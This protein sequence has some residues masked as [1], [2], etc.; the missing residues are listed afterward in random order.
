MTEETRAVD[1]SVVIP[2]LNEEENLKELHPALLSALESL[3]RTFE[4]LYVDD[5][6]TDASVNI[7]RAFAE[8]DRRVRVLV[9]PRK[10]GQ[11]AALTAGIDHAAGE[12]IVTLDADLQNDP[13][14]ISILIEKIAE[15]YDLVCGW[16][17]ERQ[18]SWIRRL[19]SWGA[20]RL[21]RMVSGLRLHDVGCTLRACRA[22]LLKEVSLYGEMH[23]FIPVYG[24]LLGARICEIPVTHHPRRHGKAKYGLARTPKV[25]LDLLVLLLLGRFIT[26]PIHLFGAIGGLTIGAG[27]FCGFWVLR[28]IYLD[29]A[30]KAHKN[31]LL[32]LAVFLALLGAQ[33]LM[34]GLLAELLTRVYYES[35]GKRIYLIRERINF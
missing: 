27:I 1:I 22:D 4:V 7:L 35:R 12:I 33:M 13:R 14:D 34:M 20:N 9:F 23:R 8:N 11:T 16:R 31:P 3:G 17:K 6:S 5:G 24:H 25:I 18:D 30:A 32:L 26:R 15:G 19:S 2:V 29:P 28:D 21:I 10:F